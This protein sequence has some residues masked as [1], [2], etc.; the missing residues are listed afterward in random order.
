MH[1]CGVRSGGFRPLSFAPF[2]VAPRKVVALRSWR[3]SVCSRASLRPF[4]GGPAGRPVVPAL[5]PGS[6]GAALARARDARYR[7]PAA[8]ALG[9]PAGA[10]GRAALS[11]LPAR[12]ALRARGLAAPALPWPC[13]RYA[14]ASS[15]PRAKKGKKKQD[16]NAGTLCLSP[17]PALTSRAFCAMLMPKLNNFLRPARDIWRCSAGRSLILIIVDFPK[18]VN[19]LFLSYCLLSCRNHVRKGVNESN[20]QV[21]VV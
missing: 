20:S 7:L 4:G 15:R 13:P 21:F 3:F 10:P 1:L 12:R 14:R 5:R 11:A 8:L 18:I 19:L 16:A 9:P 17:S 6:S 2:A